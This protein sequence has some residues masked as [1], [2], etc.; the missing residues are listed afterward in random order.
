MSHGIVGLV[1]GYVY[2]KDE[3][4]LGHLG[5]VGGDDVFCARDTFRS[6]G[7]AM[8]WCR[9]VLDGKI[10]PRRW[11]IT[12]GEAI[13][14]IV[15]GPTWGDADVTVTLGNGDTVRFETNGRDWHREGG[16]PLVLGEK[17]RTDAA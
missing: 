15:S 7:E 8:T 10:T 1:R 3:K 11:E 4:T 16:N 12:G 9:K 14:E 17:V 5:L 2:Y 13:D 6:I